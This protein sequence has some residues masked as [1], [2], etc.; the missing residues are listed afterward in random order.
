MDKNAMPSKD[1]LRLPAKAQ[2]EIARLTH[3]LEA[4]WQALVQCRS[5]LHRNLQRTRS[6]QQ[7]AWIKCASDAADSVLAKLS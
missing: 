3:L 1:F 5:E 2:D 4:A 7:R 6:S